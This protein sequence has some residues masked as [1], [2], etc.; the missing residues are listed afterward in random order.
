MHPPRTQVDG[1]HTQIEIVVFHADAQQHREAV[2]L[3]AEVMA[4]LPDT[5]TQLQSAYGK[6]PGLFARIALTFHLIEIADA[7][8]TGTASPY[9]L[10]ISEQT[11][12]RA[13]AFMLEIALPHLLRAHRLMFSTAQTGHA[14]WIAGY[15]LAER[16]ERITSRD[17]VRAY[18]SLRAPEAR[19]ELAAV[20]ASLVTI[21]WLEP[22]VP[23]NPAKPVS[24]WAVNPA[25]HVR[26]ADRAERE[27][28]R[29]EKARE[30]LAAYFA[31]LNGQTG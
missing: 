6:W 10:V 7:H 4:Q 24:A 22:E 15:I 27:Q 28:A 1:N 30:D 3:R 14:Q 19:D 2:E 5:S 20:M 26:F 9:P 17:V 8:A 31:A 25:V 29:R 18:G 12:R 11:A 23:T 13:A 21:G 16:L